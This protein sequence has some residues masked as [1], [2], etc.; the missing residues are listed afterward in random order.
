MSEFKQNLHPTHPLEAE[1]QLIELIRG[2]DAQQFS[3][4]ITRR[5]G[6]FKVTLHAEPGQPEIMGA[7]GEGETF[8]DAWHSIDPLWARNG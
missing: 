4:T 8:T 7:E 5:G 3:V 1:R 6:L 2:N